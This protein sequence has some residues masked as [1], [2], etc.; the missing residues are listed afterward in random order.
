MTDWNAGITRRLVLAGAGALPLAAAF[1]AEP[2]SRLARGSVFEDLDGST[3]RPANAPG[4]AGVMVSNGRDVVVTA[5]DGRY[6]IPV[7]PGQS[8]FVIK[9]S[10]WI[11]P[12]A[13]GTNLPRFSYVYMPDGT[14][15]A[16]DLRYRGVDP[17]GPLPAQIDFPLRKQV[18]SDRF[19]VFLLTDPQPEDADELCF[20]RDDVI[21]QLPKAADAAFGI[22]LGDLMFD[23]LSL[24]ARH[25]RIFGTVGVPWFNVTGNH[26]MNYE[27]PD[28]FYSRETWKRVFGAR[29]HAWNWGAATFFALDNVEYLGNDKYHGRFGDDQLAFVAAVLSKLPRERLVVFCMHIPL[30]TVLADDP[31][32]VIAD[33]A[34]FLRLIRDRPNTLS[35]S[36]HTHT[37]EHWYL[38]AGGGPAHHHHV[39][40]AVC[41]SWWSGPFDAR[42]IPVAVAWDGAP[43]GFHILSVDGTQASCRLVPAHDPAQGKMRLM[44]DAAFHTSGPEEARDQPQPDLVPPPIALSALDGAHLVV[45]LFEGGPKSNVAWRLNRQTSW[46]PATRVAA[47][48]PYCVE[49]FARNSATVKPW[50]TPQISTHLWQAALPSD[51][52][53]GTHRI[54]VRSRDEYGVETTAQLVFEVLEG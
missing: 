52:V 14:P 23:D 38:D 10:G 40:S 16:L 22:T 4:I 47:K 37:N 7:S 28:N 1:A 30:A 21:A 25:N 9:P 54:E 34:A 42:G 51:L 48:D 15:A 20:V 6:Q 36:G 41:G 32:N 12:L 3:L 18:E 5:Q 31:H 35:F 11:S 19:D 49:L 43:N 29:Y 17:T 26:D 44:F 13:S 24:Y 46:R 45:N 27:A 33:S 2:A 53:A 39:L 50:V 8:I